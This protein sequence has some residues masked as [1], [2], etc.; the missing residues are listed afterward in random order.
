MRTDQHDPA[1]AVEPERGARHQQIREKRHHRHRRKADCLLAGESAAAN[2]LGDQFGNVR[3]DR[4]QFDANSDTGKKAPEIEPCGAVLKGH[5]Y[6]G[7]GVPQQRIREDRAASEAIGEKATRNRA[8]EKPRKKRGDK[9]RHTRRAEQAV[10]GRGQQPALDESWRDVA[11]VQQII[12]LEEK[13]EAQQHDELPDGAR[14]RQTVES[15]GNAARVNLDGLSVGRTS[16]AARPRDG[17][18]LFRDCHTVSLR[19]EAGLVPALADARHV[20]E[21][22]A[23]LAPPPR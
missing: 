3:A 21:C 20:G 2:L 4:H 18:C 14:G 10:R 1:P 8:D 11:G 22:R 12:E 9:T 13:A 17:A 16:S 6:I 7:H 23:A 15:C 19:C 5:H